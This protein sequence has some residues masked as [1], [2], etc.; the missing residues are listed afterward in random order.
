MSTLRFENGDRELEVDTVGELI[1]ALQELPEETEINQGMGIGCRVCI[2]R[3]FGTDNYMI[4]FED[5][6]F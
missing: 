4:E 2:Q 6:D 5:I 1:R 3:E